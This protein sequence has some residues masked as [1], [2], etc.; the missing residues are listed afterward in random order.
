MA[1]AQH[2]IKKVKTVFVAAK[3]VDFLCWIFPLFQSRS[4]RLFAAMKKVETLR[5]NR[6]G[7]DFLCLHAEQET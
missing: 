3:K 5:Y 4:W 6:E 2:V 7:G 1:Q